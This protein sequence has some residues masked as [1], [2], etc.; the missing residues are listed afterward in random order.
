MVDI[1]AG[2]KTGIGCE[3]RKGKRVTVRSGPPSGCAMK[4]RRPQA[5]FRMCDEGVVKRRGKVSASRTTAS[6]LNTYKLSEPAKEKSRLELSKMR[7]ADWP[8]WHLVVKCLSL[9]A[10][11]RAMVFI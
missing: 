6:F 1:V 8:A 3:K 4:D 5:I 10:N 7:L 2:E 11:A 9:P